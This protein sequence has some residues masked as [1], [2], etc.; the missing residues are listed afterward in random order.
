MFGLMRVSTHK[1]LLE[2]Q[3]AQY[4]RLNCAAWHEVIVRNKEIRAAQ[5]GL[6]RLQRKLKRIAK[7]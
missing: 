3:H 2:V 7:P 4:F 5:K 1:R 6:L